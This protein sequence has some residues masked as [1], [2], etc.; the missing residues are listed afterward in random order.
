MK[1]VLLLILLPLIIY[2]YSDSKVTKTDTL[3]VE[4]FESGS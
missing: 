2:G 4:D 1:K 3:F